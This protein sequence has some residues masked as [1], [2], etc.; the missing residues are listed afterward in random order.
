L[1]A[2]VAATAEDAMDEQTGDVTPAGEGEPGSAEAGQPLARRRSGTLGKVGFYLAL[3]PLLG[4][5]LM[6]LLQPG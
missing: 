5:L 3:L 2:E 1:S 6:L 4:L